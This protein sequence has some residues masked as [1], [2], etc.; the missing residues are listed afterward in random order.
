MSHEKN[1]V[2]A[3]SKWSILVVAFSISIVH[4]FNNNPENFRDVKKYISKMIFKNYYKRIGFLMNNCLMIPGYEDIN[5][6]KTTFKCDDGR[7]Y[8][9]KL[10]T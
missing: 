6:G 8:M 5:D 1:K 4:C 7:I 3:S 9:E 2:N 10:P